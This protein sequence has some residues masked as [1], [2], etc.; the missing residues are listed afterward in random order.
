MCTVLMLFMS[1]IVLFDMRNAFKSGHFHI[2]SRLHTHTHTQ[3]A[4]TEHR[5]VNA[6]SL[7]IAT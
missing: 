2:I 5:M 4:G 7:L 1:V 3:I 6:F